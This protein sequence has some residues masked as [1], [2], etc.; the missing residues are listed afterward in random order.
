MPSVTQA[1]P[2]RAFSMPILPHW[3]ERRAVPAGSLP[4]GTL[5]CDQCCVSFL[6]LIAMRLADSRAFADFGRATVS[7]PF[8][9][10]ASARRLRDLEPPEPVRRYERQHPGELIH[11]DIK[12]L[13]RF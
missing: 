13:G 11:N 12:K 4:P 9:N 3:R 5:P 7:T 10:E 6:L 1:S 8:L 2:Y